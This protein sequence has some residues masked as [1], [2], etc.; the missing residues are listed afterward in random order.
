MLLLVHIEQ[1]K[2]ESKSIKELE[3]IPVTADQA[4]S[5]MTVF[6]L[7]VMIAHLN[8]VRAAAVETLGSGGLETSSS[9]YRC[10]LWYPHSS[11]TRRH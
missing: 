4:Y 11:P 10:A 6:V 5:M 9:P 1:S 3:R 7:G 8:D 2:V